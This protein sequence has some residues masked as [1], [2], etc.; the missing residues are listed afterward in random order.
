VS[1]FGAPDLCGRYT[2][3]Y[4]QDGSQCD[5]SA[6]VIALGDHIVFGRFGVQEH[7]ESGA[8]SGK[9]FREMDKI[10]VVA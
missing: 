2:I 8:K 6:R 7:R 4:S 10:A 1:I 9:W 5:F 3:F